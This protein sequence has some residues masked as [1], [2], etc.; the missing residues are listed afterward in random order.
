M[1]RILFLLICFSA[2]ALAQSS[3]QIDAVLDSLPPVQLFGQVAIAPDGHAVAYVQSGAIYLQE[4]G[5]E[6]SARRVE[7]GRKTGTESNIAW[8]PDSR[9]LA[10]LSDAA[11]PGQLELYVADLEKE[12]TAKLT[13]LTGFLD[14]PRWSPDGSTIALLFTEN[15]PRKSGPL[16]AMTRPVGVIEQKIYEQRLALVN[17][18]TYE[19]RQITPADTYIYEYDWAPDGKS[20]AAIAAQGSGDDNWWIAQLYTVD[21][22][23]GAMK[24]IFQPKLQIAEPKFSPDGNFIAVIHGLMSDQDVIGGDIYVV[25]AAGGEARN[26]TPN[27]PASAS[28][29][30]WL[31]PADLLFAANLDGDAAIATVG[32]NQSFKILWQSGET[33]TANGW[34]FGVSLARDGK[35]SAAIRSSFQQ[36]PELWAGEIGHWKRLTDVNVGS[37]P[38]WGK[39]RN[40][41][42]KND[43]MHGQGWLMLPPHYDPAKRYP[44]IVNVH[45]GPASACTSHWPGMMEAPYAALGYFVFCPNPRGS[46]GQGE[47]FTQ[48]NVR[49][50]GGGD[51]RDI[52]AGVDQVLKDFPVD[53][54]RLGIK[55]HSYGGYM[56]M[57]AETQTHRFR[58]AVAGAGLSNFQSYYGEND[59]DQ[60][61]IPYFGA[62][63]YDDPAIY[64]KSSPISFVKNVKTPTLILVGERDGEVPAPQSFEW[65][66]ALK[67]L[68]VPTELVV[69]PDEGHQI[70]QPQHWR[71]WTRRTVDWFAKYLSPS[72]TASP[73]LSAQD[74]NK[75]DAAIK[76]EDTDE[77]KDKVEAKAPMSRKNTAKENA[78]E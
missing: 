48:A 3:Q 42:W 8:S 31:S 41:H 6:G 58:A 53:P 43:S 52:M 46:Y 59:I 78:S 7:T 5:G 15:S 19:V 28:W 16:V 49:D 27:M 1:K 40:V 76:A 51:F 20:L 35:T 57:W 36:P 44:M 11:K 10:F 29:M 69:Y 18:K 68:G 47:A 64:A 22:A 71:D 63:V 54:D 30:T 4:L 65:Y 62:S 75:A 24:S 77:A 14:A 39:A 55:G 72:A 25:P 67:T 61:M 34:A 9:R 56:T 66:H 70:A 23:S 60:W 37:D 32:L 2:A 21:A 45:G 38:A 17:V 26:L 13:D 50:L 73:T 74:K 12:K 33:I